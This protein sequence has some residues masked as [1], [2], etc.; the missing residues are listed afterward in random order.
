MIMMFMIQSLLNEQA[1][2]TTSQVSDEFSV[3]PNKKERCDTGVQDDESHIS[4]QSS[5]FSFM[6]NKFKITKICDG[7]IDDFFANN[8]TDIFCNGLNDFQ[9]VQN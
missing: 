3:P 6:T 7:N 9:Y 5:C 8:I 2:D 1:Q 4:A